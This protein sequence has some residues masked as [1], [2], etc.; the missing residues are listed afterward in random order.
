MSLF[1]Q[2][3]EIRRKLRSK[4][5][6]STKEKALL[7]ELDEVDRLVTPSEEVSAS[8][9]LTKMTGPDDGRCSCCGR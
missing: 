3:I 1:P 7:S 6:L 2:L 9:R 5:Y 8:V 4:S